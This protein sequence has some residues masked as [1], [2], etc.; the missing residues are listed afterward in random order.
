[1][2]NE[3][4]R[5]KLMQFNDTTNNTGIIQEIERMTDLGDTYI[6][7]NATRLK[8]FTAI[9]N[10]VLNRIWHSI[11]MTTGNWAFDDGGYGNL[12]TARCN[13][14]ANQRKYSLPDEALTI[15]RIECL[16]EADNA[17]KLHPLIKENI[18]E[19]IDEFHDVSGTPVFYRAVAD[20]IELYPASSY[21]KDNGLIVYFDRGMNSFASDATT[22]TPGFASPYHELVP[23]KVS[24]EWLKVKQPNSPTLA[25]LMQDDMRVEQSLLQFYNK[26][27]KDYK[28]RISRGKELWK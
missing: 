23:I 28:P 13:L 2:L 24:I 20:I 5:P 9:I 14:V 10:R 18:P 3:A 25:V 6:S 1:M 4:L 17:F 16:D 11:F 8:D 12:P 19:A 22:A 26:R 21:A 7:G 15:Q 27:F